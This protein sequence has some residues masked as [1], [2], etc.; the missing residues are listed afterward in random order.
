MMRYLPRLAAAALTV[1]VLLMGRTAPADPIAGTIRIGSSTDDAARPI[2]YAADAGLF[3][4]AGLDVEIVKL[5]N[6]AAVAAA[7]AG[8]S[9]EIGKGSALT[10]ILAY[11]KGIPFTVTSNLSNYT[12]DNPNIGLIVRRDSTIAAPKDLVGKTIGLN[13]LQDQ[14]ALAMYSWLEQNGIDLG[15]VKF[16][17]IPSSVQL[18]ALDQGRVDAAVVLEPNFSSALATGRV[19]T[20]AYPWN[21]MG[22]RYTQAVMFSTTAWV[23]AHKDAID[24]VNRVLRDA[25]LYVGA[26]ENDTK[27]YAAEFAGIDVASLADFRASE[28]G[29]SLVPGDLQPTIDAAAK[30]KLIDKP[31]P[32][33]D[34]ICS[35]A[36]KSR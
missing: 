22:K 33:S 26:H 20:L 16:I 17:E 3:K 19:R 34:I 13:G 10:P 8:G 4:K 36:I 6:G 2:I 30:Y 31:F 1:A 24:R 23:S 7:V 15:S 32:A 27:I 35:C 28:R 11:A 29:V 25:G 5:S 12:S 14:N 9:V 21:A 18:A